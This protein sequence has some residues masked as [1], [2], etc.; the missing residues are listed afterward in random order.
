ME[1]KRYI[2]RFFLVREMKKNLFG[3]DTINSTDELSLLFSQ[4]TNL[5]F[6]S[7]CKKINID[8]WKKIN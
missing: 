1:V 6:S 5:E 8:K 3:I 7:E 2:S 4:L